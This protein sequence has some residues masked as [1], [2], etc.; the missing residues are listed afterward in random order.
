METPANCSPTLPKFQNYR[1]GFGEKNCNENVASGC[2]EG[3]QNW[4][5][6]HSTPRQRH[7]F[8]YL[9]ATSEMR[10]KYENLEPS[11]L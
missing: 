1:P 6:T 9:A 11:A 10:T 5:V 4:S 8:G 2:N 7:F 3:L